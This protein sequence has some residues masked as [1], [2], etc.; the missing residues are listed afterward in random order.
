[1]MEF[2]RIKRVKI[3]NI[4]HKNRQNRNFWSKSNKFQR[5]KG[6]YNMMSI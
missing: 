5:D 3:D 1:M 6:D 4:W 2:F